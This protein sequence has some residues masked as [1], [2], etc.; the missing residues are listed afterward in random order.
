M[1]AGVVVLAGGFFQSSLVARAVDTSCPAVTLAELQ[2]CVAGANAAAGNTDTTTITLGAPVGLPVS[3]ALAVAANKHIVITAGDSASTLDRQSTTGYGITVAA[4]ASL[5]LTN[6]TVN[7]SATTAANSSLVYVN[8]GTLEIGQGGVLQNSAVTGVGGAVSASGASSL[9]KV[10]D[11][12][13]IQNNSATTNGGGVY[14]ETGATLTMTGG[15]IIGNSAAS[16]GGI[17]NDSVAALSIAGSMIAGNMASSDGGG[18]YSVAGSAS[19]LKT[20]TIT[21]TTIGVS[22]QPNTAGRNG[23]GIFVGGLQNTTLNNVAVS[24]N[25]AGASGGGIYCGVSSSAAAICSSL[26]LNGSSVSNN[27]AAQTANGSGGGIYVSAATAASRGLVTLENNSS[28]TNN[29]V[30]Y[31]ADGTGSDFGGGGGG[32]YMLAYVSVDLQDTSTVNNNM[33]SASGGGISGAGANPLVT[34]AENATVKNNASGD[35]GGGIYLA[36]GGV[37]GGGLISGNSSPSGGGISMSGPCAVTDMRIIGNTAVT[38]GGGIFTWSRLTVTGGEISGN[39]SAGI[40]GGI[41]S[42]ANPLTL[43]GD[44]KII[45]NEAGTDGGGVQL[46]GSTAYLSMSDDVVVSG[47]TAGQNGGG[48]WSAPRG[49]DSTGIQTSITSNVKITDNSAEGDGGG[50]YITRGSDTT[51]NIARL[52]GD[53]QISGNTAAGGGGGIYMAPGSGQVSLGDEATVTGNT[54]GGDGGGVW[55]A[56]A[57][58]GNLDVGSGVV[59]SGNSASRSSDSIAPVDQPTYDTHVLAPSSAWTTGFTQG[60]N[61]FDISYLAPTAS[62]LFQ[63]DADH[64]YT[65]LDE[66]TVLQGDTATRPDGV[67]PSHPGERV[68]GWRQVSQVC[69]ATGVDDDPATEDVDESQNCREEVADDFFDFTTPVLEDIVLRAVWGPACQYDNTLAPEDP[70]CQPLQATVVFQDD[71]DHDYTQL[72]EQTVPQGGTVTDPGGTFPSHPG[73][74]VVGWRQV[75]QVCEATGVDDDPDTTDVDESQTC[76]EVVDDDFFDFTTPVLG[77]M[78]LRAVWGPVCEYDSTLGAD[79]PA[80][81]APVRMVP[82]PAI[83][84]TKTGTVPDPEHPKAGDVVTW[85]FEIA[86]KGNVDL[87]G[88]MIDDP[89]L[90]SI[91]CTLDGKAFTLGAASTDVLPVGETAKCTATATVLQSDIDNTGAVNTA[92]VSGKDPDGTPV[93]FGPVTATRSLAQNPDVTIK[94]DAYTADANHNGLADVGEQITFTIT[95]ENLGNVTVNQLKVNDTMADLVL[96]CVNQATGQTVENGQI[97]LAPGQ[98]VVCVTS[99]YMITAGDAANGSVV[100]LAT[101]A[102]GVGNTPPPALRLPGD[103]NTPGSLGEGSQAVVPVAPQQKAPTGGWLATGSWLWLGGFAPLLAG[104]CLLLWR[105]RQHQAGEAV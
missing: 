51:A 31:K 98:T 19:A 65:Q 64:D 57:D 18:I 56:Y 99:P 15:S 90:P 7:G 30:G 87:T 40:G 86:N 3:G 73:G 75:S 33:A 97:S 41:R 85:S 37:S 84:L 77:D 11:G 36:G 63:D 102:A 42:Q 95:L 21:D 26:T 34:I 93:G 62:V 46:T 47:N 55:V 53:V 83:T 9:V 68:V 32:I 49:A 44:L 39:Q 91:T 2:A 66:Q 14:L 101:F 29:K 70:A 20:V 58:L 69:E 88:V 1:T 67:Y 50:I 81:Q 52:D 60:Y 13:V 54:A 43:A 48:I 38:Q 76:A 80:C 6:V 16:G 79:D 4:G 94:K 45:N 22:A 92:S 10:G 59:F 27:L 82:A 100:N 17:Y 72:D 105:R 23:G 71:A 24:Y 104:A 12:A 103:S 8:G 74:R 35:T 78:V 28:I 25:I 5:V 96:A 61:N 89:Q